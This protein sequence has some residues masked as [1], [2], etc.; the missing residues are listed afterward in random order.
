M[1]RKYVKPISVKIEVDSFEGFEGLLAG[2]HETFHEAVLSAES[3]KTP[4]DVVLYRLDLEM[5]ISSS[6]DVTQFSPDVI[7]AFNELSGDKKIVFSQNVNPDVINVVLASKPQLAHLDLSKCL[8]SSVEAALCN[9]LDNN[10]EIISL[11]IDRATPGIVTAASNSS[12]VNLSSSGS[13][14]GSGFITL[15]G[16]ATDLYDTCLV[17][18]EKFK[19]TQ[20]VAMASTV[21]SV[22]T[23]TA[24]S[25][26]SELKLEQKEAEFLSAFLSKF[27]AFMYNMSTEGEST[28]MRSV[29]LAVAERCEGAV[30]EK[31][32]RLVRKLPEPKLSM[33]VMDD[34]EGAPH[35]VVLDSAHIAQALDTK[36]FDASTMTDSH[37]PQVNDRFVQTDIHHYASRDTQVELSVSRDVGV[38]DCTRSEDSATMTVVPL[39][40]RSVWTQ[41]QSSSVNVVTPK[42]LAFWTNPYETTLSLVFGKRDVEVKNL[43]DTCHLDCGDDV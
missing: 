2:A 1:P 20:E 23:S 15:N 35:V 16:M 28:C 25:E 22:S 11:S 30:R 9:F 5:S 32:D 10:V 3:T 40:V 33:V 39:H 7:S 31:A 18:F 19:A 17:M 4:E 37:A 26:R 38:G 21:A 12:L 36:S 27:V 41:A 43:G 24:S 29:A 8:S 42:V 13:V 6:C 34:A 14:T